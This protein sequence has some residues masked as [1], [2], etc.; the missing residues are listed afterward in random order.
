MELSWKQV[1]SSTTWMQRSMG[2]ES[3]SERS[4]K[5][6][7]CSGHLE[8]LSNLLLLWYLTRVMDWLIDWLVGGWVDWFFTFDAFIK[9]SYICKNGKVKNSVYRSSLVAQRVKDLALSTLWLQSLLWPGNFP[10]P[11]TQPKK[12]WVYKIVNMDRNVEKRKGLIE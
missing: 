6:P 4:D 2:H 3:G 9:A 11:W 1:L 5:N 12:F 8:V 10:M 7:R